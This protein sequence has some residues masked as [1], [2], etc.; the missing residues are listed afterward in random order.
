MLKQL[1]IF[2]SV[3]RLGWALVL[4]L[5]FPFGQAS[6]LTLE[7]QL[8]LRTNEARGAAGLPPLEPDESLTRIARAH[9]AEMAELNYFSHGSPVTENATL[10]RRAANAGSYA[11]NLGENL[12]LVGNDDPANASVEGWLGSPGH[13]ANLLSAEFTHVGFGTAHYPDGRTVVAQEFALE[14][15]L[16]ERAVLSPVA[17]VQLDVL[18]EL[19]QE[20]EI[21]VF[22]AGTSS[23]SVRLGSGPQLLHVPL[24]RTPEL[25]LDIRIGVRP[26]GSSGAFS[27]GG[28]GALTL[29][30]WSSGSGSGTN[31]SEAMVQ[32][33]SS[34]LSAPAADGYTVQLTFAEP[35]RFALTAWQNGQR[36]PLEGSG[37]ALSLKL[38]DATIPLNL[39]VAQTDGRYRVLF[40][41]MPRLASA[42]GLTPT[43]D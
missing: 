17:D 28:E 11:K 30:G 15:A 24:S 38:I 6:D 8:L 42:T 35:P 34:R 26:V 41:F 12:A 23:Q 31:E 4:V 33:V 9:A 36:I 43:S 13:R 19:T 1:F 39:G 16:L 18:L 2:S 32:L 21:A 7:A 5:L 10:S 3:S 29:E 20:A 27:L 37:R 14:P 25:P 22:F 40:S